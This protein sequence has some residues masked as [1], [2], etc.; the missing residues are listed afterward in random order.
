MRIFA[1]N[2]F[3][4][5]LFLSALFILGTAHSAYAQFDD[6]G[7][8]IGS[9][10]PDFTLQDSDGNDVSYDVLKGDKGLVMAFVRSAEWCPY[11]QLQL[12]DI[13]KHEDAL[14]ELGYNLV[15]VSYDSVAQ[16]G[17]FDVKYDIPYVMVSDPDSELIKAFG[18]LNET[19]EPESR[20]YGIPHPAIFVIHNP[21]IIAHKYYEEDYK[22]RPD[23]N[24]IIADIKKDA[25][26]AQ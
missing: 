12:Q 22:E 3:A 7:P 5:A 16:L 20:A 25:A 1:L 10:I 21:G 15:S 9:Q 2:V 23:M 24:D 19:V 14:N 6:L 11:C 13:G 4:T 26:A 18:I 17:T 8:A